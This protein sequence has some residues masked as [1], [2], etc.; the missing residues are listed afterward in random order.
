MTRKT[1]AAPESGYIRR[2]D[3]ERLLAESAARVAEIERDLIERI[4]TRV[5]AGD[6]SQTAN[7]EEVQ[8]ALAQLDAASAALAK[9]MDLL[10]NYPNP[11]VQ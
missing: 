8:R 9:A 1:D 7:T 3:A 6:N 5:A 4:L 11:G 10:P 2:I